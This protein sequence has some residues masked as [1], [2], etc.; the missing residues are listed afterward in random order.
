MDNVWLNMHWFDDG[1][2]L[3]DNRARVQAH[4]MLC[5]GKYYLPSIEKSKLMPPPFW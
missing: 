1:G 5:A 3:H 4:R 2:V